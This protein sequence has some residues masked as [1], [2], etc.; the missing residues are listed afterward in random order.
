MLQDLQSP[1]ESYAD[2]IGRFSTSASNARPVFHEVYYK[3]FAMGEI[4]FATSG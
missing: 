1:H 4:G 2:F 3:S